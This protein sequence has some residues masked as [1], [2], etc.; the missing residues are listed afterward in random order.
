MLR[1]WQIDPRHARARSRGARPA[2]GAAHAAGLRHPRSNILGTIMPDL[3]RS[4]RLVHAR[5]AELCVDGVAWPR[6]AH[7]RTGARL[8]TGTC[9]RFYKTYGPHLAVLWGRHD[10]LLE[11]D[12]VSTT[13]SIGRDR[14]P[15]KLQ[16]GNVNYELAWGCAG[17]LDYLDQ[18]SDDHGADAFERAFEL[19][20]HEAGWRRACCHGSRPQRCARDRRAQRRRLRSGGDHHPSPWRQRRPDDIVAASIAPRSAIRHG[21]FHA[22]R[23]IERLSLAD[24]GGVVRVSMV[25]YNTLAEVDPSHRSAR[26]RD[27]LDPLNRSCGRP[28]GRTPR[29]S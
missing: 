14:V 5:G 23:L 4:P 24:I 19:A 16:P 10:R 22:R 8:S 12:P 21:D 13:S 27:A 15:Y 28:T 3:P 29:P 18:L 20:T 2:A 9:S 17:I 25:H 7:R 11:L 26:R 1:E 6:T